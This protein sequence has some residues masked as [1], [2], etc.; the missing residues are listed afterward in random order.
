MLRHEL[1]D[2]LAQSVVARAS[3]ND[4]PAPLDRRQVNRRLKHFLNLLP[5]IRGHSKSGQ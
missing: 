3:L 2:L 5:A 4:V 1:L